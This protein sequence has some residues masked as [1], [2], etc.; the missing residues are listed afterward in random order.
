[1][2]LMELELCR[3]DTLTHDPRNSRLHDDRNLE[4][5][6]NSLE[7]FGQQKPIVVDKDG[8]VVAGNGTL[9]AAAELGWTEIS[10]VRTGLGN[11]EAVAYAIADNRTSDLAD[12]DLEQ[13]QTSLD[14][15]D[16]DLLDY[17]GFDI[18]DR[19]QFSMGG[20]DEG[21]GSDVQSG[22]DKPQRQAVIQYAII[23]DD[24]GQQKVWFDFL[25][26]LKAK[27]PSEVTIAERIVRFI[28]ESS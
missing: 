14:S 25:R 17:T 18:L 22:Q 1:M 6:R 9:T 20:L 2:C 10:C 5:I 21:E 16:P 19:A 27:Y 26:G 8:V 23:F 15:L 11:Q 24:D 7:R 13:L 3:I 12:W 28:E 4:S